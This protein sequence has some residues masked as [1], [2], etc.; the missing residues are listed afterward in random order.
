MTVL[1]LSLPLW[2]SSTK[3]VA[4]NL[5]LV[6][7]VLR[8]RDRLRGEVMQYMSEIVGLHG[9]I[10]FISE[11]LALIHDDRDKLNSELASLSSDRDR[12]RCELTQREAELM[13]L[14]SETAA[15]AAKLA[16]IHGVF[17]EPALAAAFDVVSDKPAYT[18]SKMREVEP[19]PRL[20]DAVTAWIARGS[21]PEAQETEVFKR[22]VD[23]HLGSRTRYFSDYIVP[24]VQ[25]MFDLSGKEVI[26]VGCGTGSSTA[27]FAP[28]AGVVHS[29]EIDESSAEI[30]ELRFR[31]SDLKNVKLYREQFTGTSS[32]S[33]DLVLL[34]ATLEHMTIE[35]RI[36]ILRAGWSALRPGGALVVCETPNRLSLSDP[37]TSFLPFFQQIPD[38]LKLHYLDHSPRAE[39]IEHM[40]RVQR[41]KPDGTMISL[42]RWGF[43]ASFHE[44]ECA[45]GDEVHATV[46]ADGYEPQILALHP[47]NFEDA[48]LAMAFERLGMAKHRAFTRTWLFLILAKPN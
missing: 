22:T 21:S 17:A 27:A 6:G 14:G 25:Q 42:A 12:L 39:F 29:Y 23:E 32:A 9:R 48:M 46:I 43:G 8:D 47:A 45:I 41:D 33:A 2:R 38:E 26:E 3:R 11:Q 37:H 34:A 20:R 19:D 7:P 30:A 40:Q 31:L 13:S 35:E 44:F 10:S 5:P 16:R 24:W 4:C 1:P 36:A 28:H 15:L 18:P